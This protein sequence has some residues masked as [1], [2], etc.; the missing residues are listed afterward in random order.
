[1]NVDKNNMMD[2]KTLRGNVKWTQ[3]GYGEFIDFGV[4]TPKS[5][6]CSDQ[7]SLRE[8][9]SSDEYP[10]AG[11]HT[12]EQAADYAKNGWDAG[13]AAIKD[14]VE[15]DS[16]LINIEHALVGHAVD[17]GRYMTGVPDTMV[18]FYDDSYRNKAPLTVYTKLTYLADVN[19]EEAM[20]YCSKI[21]ETIAI[22]NRTFN[23]KLVGVF[24][25]INKGRVTNMVLVNIKDTDERF[26]INNL[27]FA[28]N[29]AFF[30]R[31]WF[32][33]LETTDMWES[34]YGQCPDGTFGDENTII[35]DALRR[36][37]PVNEQVLFIPDVY[38][39]KR[40]DPVK[41]AQDAVR[42]QVSRI[43]KM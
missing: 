15:T 35:G 4:T 25:S 19:G 42:E 1:M 38:N 41:I 16:T 2:V 6:T 22:L 37:A 43:S 9:P 23:V 28:Y 12:W 26:V 24:D 7:S 36:V 18:S 31:F 33:W 32:K 13:I 29:P 40:I 5:E 14:Y 17:V 10:W 39:R 11:T 27:A 8:Y 34:G 30:R 20:E 21:L 3:F